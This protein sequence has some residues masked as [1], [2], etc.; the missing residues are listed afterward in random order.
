MYRAFAYNIHRRV[1]DR[2]REHRVFLI[3]DAA[4]MNA[5]A[6]GQGINL[7]M[8]DGFNLGWKLALVCRGDAY[9]ALLD[10]YEA[11]RLPLAKRVVGAV[12]R[13]YRADMVSGGAFAALSNSLTSKLTGVLVRVPPLRDLI[14]NLIGQT[15]ISYR[16]SPLSADRGSRRGLRAGD[17]V[18]AHPAL[19]R[20][21]VDRMGVQALVFDGLAGGGA[22]SLRSELTAA[23]EQFSVHV[24]IKR[25]PRSERALHGL[26]GARQPLFALIRPDGYVLFRGQTEDDVAALGQFLPRWFTRRAL[27]A[28]ADAL[29]ERERSTDRDPMLEPA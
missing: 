19:T 27:T 11:E 5:P 26:F 23:L 7:G 22:A 8:G 13:V 28:D 2:F 4:H 9:P 16:R 18:P 1:A 20:L 21:G 12:D 24:E 10:S 17:R 29:H 6:G 3:G 15:W 25:V 14:A